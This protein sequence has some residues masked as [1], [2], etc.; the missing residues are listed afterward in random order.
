M[1]YVIIKVVEVHLRAKTKHFFTPEKY[2]NTTCNQT[3]VIL[4]YRLGPQL[5]KI[6]NSNK[7]YNIVLHQKQVSC[8]TRDVNNIRR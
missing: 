1:R 3:E 7:S 8:S 2:L 6:I 4:P 5:V